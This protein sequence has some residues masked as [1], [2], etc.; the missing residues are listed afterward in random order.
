MVSLIGRGD[1]AA[2]IAFDRIKHAPLQKPGKAHLLEVEKYVHYPRTVHRAIAWGALNGA[3]GS[4]VLA[5]GKGPSVGGV[6]AE[7]HYAAIK[8]AADPS[9][10][11]AATFGA[12][13]Q[14]MPPHPLMQESEQP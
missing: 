9:H 3:N 13:Q 10:E 7:A 4:Y 6:S 14:H 11:A 1:A 12:R 2:G 8:N 5:V